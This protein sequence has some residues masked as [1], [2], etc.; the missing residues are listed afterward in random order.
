MGIFSPSLEYIGRQD[1]FNSPSSRVLGLLE[2][3]RGIITAAVRAVVLSHLKALSPHPYVLQ[4]TFNLAS[5]KMVLV[6][7]LKN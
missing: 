6:L 2:E 4:D 5:S 1:G 7:P 3:E